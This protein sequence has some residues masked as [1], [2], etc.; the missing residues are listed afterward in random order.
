MDS[1]PTFRDFEPATFSGRDATCTPGLRRGHVFWSKARFSGDDLF[2]EQRESRSSS[3]PHEYAYKSS[4]FWREQA[5]NSRLGFERKGQEILAESFSCTGRSQRNRKHRGKAIKLVVDSNPAF[6]LASPLLEE[7]EINWEVKDRIEVALGDRS[8]TGQNRE[9]RSRI[10]DTLSL[11]KQASGSKPKPGTFPDA[12][13]HV[14]VKEKAA[15]LLRHLPW[16]SP[17]ALNTSKHLLSG[18]LAAAVAR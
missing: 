4:P 5:R 6:D 9:S 11:G 17:D 2:E 18:A 8:E 16:L 12:R 14:A 15:Q 1:Q 3:D 13:W 7:V 10:Q